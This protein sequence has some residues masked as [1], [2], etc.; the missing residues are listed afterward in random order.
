[1]L[2]VMCS[3]AHLMRWQIDA[4]AKQEAL[5]TAA[6]TM[7]AWKDVKIAAVRGLVAIEWVLQISPQCMQPDAQAAWGGDSWAPASCGHRLAG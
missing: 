5:P 1:M 2:E 7:A 3:A 6:K 4:E